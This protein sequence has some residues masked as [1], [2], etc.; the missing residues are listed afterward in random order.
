VSVLNFSLRPFALLLIAAEEERKSQLKNIDVTV[1]TRLRKKR[2]VSPA[3]DSETT[4]LTPKAGPST[5]QRSS[6]SKR[7]ETCVDMVEDD[8]NYQETPTSPIIEISPGTYS[9][10]YYLLSSSFDVNTLTTIR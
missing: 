4:I 2:R 5:P 10:F 8:D 1:D 9:T 6:S 7:P 3:A